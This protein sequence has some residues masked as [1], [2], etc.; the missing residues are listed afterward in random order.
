MTEFKS[1]FYNALHDNLCNSDDEDSNVKKCYIS[2]EKADNTYIKLECG[3]GFNYGNIFDEVYR[4]KVLSNKKEICI[5]KKNQIKCPYCRNI[6]NSLLPIMKHFPEK[7]HINYPKRYRM[8]LYTCEYIFKSGK[9]KGMK[10]HEKC[11]SEYCDKCIK[12]KNKQEI[13]N[14]NSVL[15]EEILVSGKRKGDKCGKICKQQE[16]AYCGLHIKKHIN[17]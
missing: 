15:C 17:K 6:Q 14:E 9:K 10:C 4:Q 11:E 5:L 8:K 2:D 16:V 13:K 1:L 3:H 12:R 7:T